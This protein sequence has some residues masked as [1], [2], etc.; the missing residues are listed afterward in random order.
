MRGVGQRIHMVLH[1]VGI[2]WF[3]AKDY[4]AIRKRKGNDE[5]R[6]CA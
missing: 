5:E 1:M 6:V 2:A 4:Q 3:K